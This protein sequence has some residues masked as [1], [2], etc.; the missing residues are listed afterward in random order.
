MAYI[1]SRSNYIQKVKI[2]FGTLMGEQE[3]K[4]VYLVLREP[5]TEQMMAFQKYSGQDEMELFN[6]FKSILPTIIVEDNFYEDE[7]RARHLSPEEITAVIYESLDVTAKL[8]GEYFNAAFLPESRGQKS[9]L[10]PLRR[11]LRRETQQHC[12]G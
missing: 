11:C 10:Q 7:S 9:N 12:N 4:E 6:Y 1:K 8:F 3:D 2:E 5:S